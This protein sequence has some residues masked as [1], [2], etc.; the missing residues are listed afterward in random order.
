M[1]AIGLFN[2]NLFFKFRCIQSCL[3]FCGVF[4]LVL[5]CALQLILIFL[6]FHKSNYFST[7]YIIM[8]SRSYAL[9]KSD[10]SSKQN[11]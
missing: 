1:F 4:D 6:L 11:V 7:R 2:L 3:N 5:L 10:E 8:L 9:F